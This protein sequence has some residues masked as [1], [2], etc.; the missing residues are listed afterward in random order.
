MKSLIDAIVK[1]SKKTKTKTVSAVFSA[2][3]VGSAKKPY[4]DAMF[5]LDCN[6]TMSGKV[7]GKVGASLKDEFMHASQLADFNHIFGLDLLDVVPAAWELLPF[8]WLVD[9][10]T[11]LGDFFAL[12]AFKRAQYENG[13]EVTIKDIQ[14][15]LSWQPTRCVN[16]S[17]F[18]FS[19]T[20][21][22]MKRHEFT[23]NRD[24]LDVATFLPELRYEIPHLKQVANIAAVAA[25]MLIKPNRSNT[26]SK[27]WQAEHIRV[28]RLPGI[29]F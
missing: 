14:K 13:Y 11:N 10:F 18:G 29:S 3:Q 16:S 2:D 21:G 25:G 1:V 26:L 12:A 4:S 15:V 28:S 23:Y 24:P 27:N 7:V 20:P 9:Y 19:G 17:F 8:S 6:L 22:V 5:L